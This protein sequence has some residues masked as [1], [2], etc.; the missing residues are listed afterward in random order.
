M[1]IVEPHLE[2][3]L[4][5]DTFACRGGKGRVR[6]LQRTQQFAR[7]HSRFFRLDISKYFD[8]ISHDRLLGLWQR[9][10]KD[11]KLLE[12]MSAIVTGYRRDL[13]KGLPI[14]SLTSQHLA[15]FYLGWFDRFVK[16]KLR[17]RGYVRYMDDVAI[18][19][20][21]TA[22]A[23]GIEESVRAVPVRRVGP[24]AEAGALR[25]SDVARDGL[26]GVPGLPISPGAEPPEPRSVPTAMA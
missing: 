2:R 21:D 5:D 7:Q 11:K 18:W 6:C 26:P 3:W 9:R 15:N 23:K 20:P 1:N 8:S 16:E 12:V 19:L 17:I 25:E 10:F 14:G 24:A 4:I 13:G 22:A